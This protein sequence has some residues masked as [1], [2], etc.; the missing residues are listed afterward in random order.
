MSVSVEGARSADPPTSHG[1][2]LAI[3]FSTLPELA[4]V[5]SPL[6]SAAKGLISASQPCGQ[7]MPPDAIELLGLFGELPG[8]FGIAGF[9]GLVERLAAGA[10]VRAEV[11]QHLF[12]HEELLV[13]RPAVGPLGQADLLVTQRGAVGAVRV[14][15][16]R[17]AVGDHALDDDQR[18]PVASS[19]ENLA[20]AARRAARSLTSSTFSTFQP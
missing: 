12:G 5:A 14:V 11:G 16:V 19:S 18:R 13:F 20:S 10:D 2:R 3:W 9:P 6:A 15:L 1:N 4:R 8:I 17:S 7:F